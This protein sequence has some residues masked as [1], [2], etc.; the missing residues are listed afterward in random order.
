MRYT[1]SGSCV[2]DSPKSIKK[3]IEVELMNHRFMIIT[4]ELIIEINSKIFEVTL[5][6]PNPPQVLRSRCEFI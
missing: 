4:C 5:S 2:C 6:R 1:E 3:I